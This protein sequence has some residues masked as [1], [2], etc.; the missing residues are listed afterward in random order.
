VVSTAGQDTLLKAIYACFDGVYN[1]N[2]KVPG[3]V[4]TSGNLA[5]IECKDDTAKVSC[6]LRSSVES[7]KEDIANTVLS[8]LSLGEAHVEL[9]GGYPGW[10]PNP[11]SSLLNT[12]KSVYCARYGKE[13]QVA[14]VHAGLECGIIGSKYPSLDMVSCGP[15]IKFPHSPEEKVHTGSVESFWNYLLE[16][17]K[18]I[19][20]KE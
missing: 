9:S 3:V 4:E 7:E 6:L 8:A 1:M 2:H 18:K 12:M 10:E 17:L 13:P 19:G 20:D 14:V 15:T 5:I 16:V 11:Q